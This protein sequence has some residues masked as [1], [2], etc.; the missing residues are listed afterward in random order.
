M[1]N[2]R[3]HQTLS[4]WLRYGSLCIAVAAL[5]GCKTVPS[6]PVTEALNIS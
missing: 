5:A 4:H 2:M 6:N 1:L 3:I